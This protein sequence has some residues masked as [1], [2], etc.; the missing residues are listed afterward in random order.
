MPDSLYVHKNN[1]CAGTRGPCSVSAV[2]FMVSMEILGLSTSR[3][4]VSLIICWE[5]VGCFLVSE[6]KGLFPTYFSVKYFRFQSWE[7]S[8]L[9]MTV[10][11][12]C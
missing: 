4:I 2:R 5:E 1:T 12:N 11:V 6:F 10:V 8:F 7:F 9:L 3:K